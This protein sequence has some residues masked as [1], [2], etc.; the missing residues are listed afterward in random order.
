MCRMVRRGRLRACNAHVSGEGEKT[1]IIAESPYREAAR[2]AHE[3]L[4]SSLVSE[5]LYLAQN[6]AL[7]GS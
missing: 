2:A 3:Q 1:K 5:L 6:T 4:M 7:L